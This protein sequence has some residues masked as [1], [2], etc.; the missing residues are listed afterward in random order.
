MTAAGRKRGGGGGACGHAPAGGRCAGRRLR[1]LPERP[2]AARRARGR[3][4]RLAHTLLAEQQA[5]VADADHGGQAR[6][7][8]Q[9]RG[10]HGR[11][12]ALAAVQRLQRG[13]RGRGLQLRRLQAE[14]VAQLLQGFALLWLHKPG[15]CLVFVQTMMVL[16]CQA[17]MQVHTRRS[18]P[19]GWAVRQV[20]E[21]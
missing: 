11:R 1:C 9:V 3:A 8:V 18:H 17:V 12:G 13:L 2:G 16:F 5:V 4:A 14:Q 21:A 20:T 7:R 10:Q 15:R 6:Q 19:P